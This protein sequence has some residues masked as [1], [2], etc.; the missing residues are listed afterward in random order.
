MIGDGSKEAL[1]AEQ[2]VK[3]IVTPDK[4]ADYYTIQV[5][6]D[7]SQIFLIKTGE[8]FT[9]NSL[10]ERILRTITEVLKCKKVDK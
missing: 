4:Y 10:P 3:V 5:Y 6:V 9:K 1:E 8:M 7:G 2:L